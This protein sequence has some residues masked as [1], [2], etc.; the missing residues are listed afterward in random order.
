MN[1]KLKVV[2][3]SLMLIILIFISVPFLLKGINKIH[4]KN[5]DYSCTIDADCAIKTTGCDMCYGTKRECV[6]ENS[7][8]GWCLKMPSF[9]K[10]SCLGFTP[11]PDSCACENNRCKISSIIM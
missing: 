4:N 11:T 9:A 2:L 6:N 3:I 7:I 1:K 8:K 10:I 5:I